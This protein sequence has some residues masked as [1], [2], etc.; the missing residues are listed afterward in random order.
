M[1]RRPFQADQ[2]THGHLVSDGVLKWFDSDAGKASR[3]SDWVALWRRGVRHRAAGN[4]RRQR[5]PR[6][7][8]CVNRSPPVL[9]SRRACTFQSLPASVSGVAKI[10]PAATRCIDQQITC[11]R[12]CEQGGR[13]KSGDGAGYGLALSALMLSIPEYC[14]SL[15]V[16]C[17][18]HWR[19]RA[20]SARKTL[21]AAL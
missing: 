11:R 9:S 20:A 2:R 5:C 4:R 3:T 8:S 13:E 19:G 16:F 1:R 10:P 7:Q 21:A 14:R 18:R 6:R 12:V 17:E 15:Q